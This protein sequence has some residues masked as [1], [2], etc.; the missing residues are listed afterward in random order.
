MVPV[1]LNIHQN[2]I[3]YVIPA[4]LESLIFY[5]YTGQVYFLPL[6]SCGRKARQEGLRQHIS[7]YPKYP[8]CSPK[9][10]Y[11]LADEVHPSNRYNISES[12][13]Y[14]HLRPRQFGFDELRQK[15][16]D[17]IFSQLSAENILHEVFS[18]FSSR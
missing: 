5:V 8:I 13:I 12:L 4:R 2:N 15:A 16:K 6:K 1:P 10:M 11:R 3:D 14:T 7:R 17:S 18:K 9:S